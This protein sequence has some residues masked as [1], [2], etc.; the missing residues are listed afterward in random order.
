MS[1]TTFWALWSN[2]HLVDNQI[3]PA[4]SGLSCKIQPIIDTLSSTFVKCYSPI[5]ELSVDEAMVKYKGPV[6]GKVVMPRYSPYR[7]VLRFGAAPVLLL[8]LVHF[9]GVPWQTYLSV[10]R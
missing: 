6:G 10:D 3:V 9:S 8:V 5:Q 2:V 7:K 1:V 4:G